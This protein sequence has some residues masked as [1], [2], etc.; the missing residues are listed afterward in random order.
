MSINEFISDAEYFRLY[1]D[2]QWY[3]RNID[4]YTQCFDDLDEI[5]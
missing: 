2:D 4:L 5:I 1:I 3:L